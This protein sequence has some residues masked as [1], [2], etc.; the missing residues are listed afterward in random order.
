VAPTNF[1][2]ASACESAYVDEIPKPQKIRAM[3]KAFLFM[4]ISPQ[5][6]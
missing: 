1:L 4:I 6:F 3:I 5:G 2:P